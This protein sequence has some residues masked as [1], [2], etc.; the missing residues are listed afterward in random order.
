M[1][2][3]TLAT[4]KQQ[5]EKI[6]TIVLDFLKNK[7]IKNFN[8]LEVGCGTGEIAAYFA[9]NVKTM[10][11]IEINRKLINSPKLHENDKL[12]YSQAD[13]SC[14]PF[15]NSV[16]DLVLLPQVYEHTVNQEKMF[17]EIHRVLKP[18][19]ICF[20]SGPNRFQIIEQH[21]FLPFLSWLPQKLASFYLKILNKGDVYD[22]YPRS[23]WYLNSLT[24]SFNKYDYTHKMLKYP[25]KFK[26]QERL[27]PFSFSIFP[28]WLLK[29][30]SPFY[31]N[32]NWI[33]QKF[34]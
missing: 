1:F 32:F 21:H 17:N 23:F 27:G 19:G 24:K 14:L 25:E 11:G 6:H 12:G 30:F 9:D 13:G 33:L 3:H 16:F 4:R 34:Q 20:F 2:I 8:C 31:P 22:I 28:T 18:G 26:V 29:S 5:A 15:H 7:D 10:W